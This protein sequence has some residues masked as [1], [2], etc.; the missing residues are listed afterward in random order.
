LPSVSSTH[1]IV[2]GIPASVAARMMPTASGTLLIV[3]AETMS[4]S[5]ARKLSICGR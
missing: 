2:A 5:A 4:A 1:E 3:N